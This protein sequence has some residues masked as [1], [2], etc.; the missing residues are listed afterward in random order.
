MVYRPNHDIVLK[1][2]S[3]LT[4]IVSEPPSKIVR[5]G[6]LPRDNQFVFCSNEA[7][8]SESVNAVYETELQE[9]S[10]PK[11][12]STA[13]P[14]NDQPSSLILDLQAQ[15]AEMKNEMGKIN[16]ELDKFNRKFEKELGRVNGKLSE[17]TSIND[18]FYKE[19]SKVKM[20]TGEVKRELGEVKWELC[21]VNG[22]LSLQADINNKLE[23]KLLKFQRPFN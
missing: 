18:R 5:W 1:D 22:K 6:T 7:E 23:D 15:M 2:N 20:K 11:I 12:S 17:Q 13:T 9:K 19:L 21:R 14:S 10:G 3:E 4:D 8:K 16:R